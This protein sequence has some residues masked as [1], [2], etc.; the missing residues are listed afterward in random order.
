MASWSVRCAILLH[1]APACTFK[2]RNPQ[3]CPVFSRRNDIS[4][5][6]FMGLNF[7]TFLAFYNQTYLI[8]R[9]REF[10]ANT[11]C[12]LA[13]PSICISALLAGRTKTEEIR[14]VV[15]LIFTDVQQSVCRSNETANVQVRSTTANTRQRRRPWQHSNKK[16]TGSK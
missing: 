12:S 16:I 3:S 2:C 14:T 5:W 10:S 13:V 15:K 9:A 1:Q 4:C 7:L 11:L 8:A 6:C